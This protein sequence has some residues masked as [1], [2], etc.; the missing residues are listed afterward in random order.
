MEM[1]LANGQAEKLAA[2]MQAEGTIFPSYYDVVTHPLWSVRLGALVV[3]ET[4]AESAPRLAAT[5]AAPLWERYPGLGPAAKGDVVYL[6]GEIGAT[7]LKD[8][9]QDLYENEDDPELRDAL[10]ETLEKLT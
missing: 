5:M 1:M 6:L 3:A 2:L 7:Q 8:A 4:L 9:L 10:S